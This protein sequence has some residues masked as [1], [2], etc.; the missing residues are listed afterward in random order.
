MP[1]V[2]WTHD[3][4]VTAAEAEIA[5]FAAALEGADWSAPVPTCPEWSIADLA[6][7]TGTIQRWAEALVRTGTRERIVPRKLGVVRPEAPEDLPEWI[8]EGGRLLGRTLRDHD[9]DEPVWAWGPD[10]HVRFWSRRIVHETAVHRADLEFALGREPVIDAAVA[11]DG[12][13]ELLTN[14]P[15]AAPFSPGIE[16]LRGDGDVLVFAARDSGARW[17]VRFRPDGYDWAR[18]DDGGAGIEPDAAV[19]ADVVDLY[20][21]LHRRRAPG[22]PRVEVSGDRALVA[23][24]AENSAI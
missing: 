17:T 12:I 15:S 24:W 9:P 20:L 4:H 14:L 22:D 10:P 23:H 19:T 21:F 18:D 7:H 13:G 2:P 1:P 8:A 3:R 11:D 5:A 16:R 6:R